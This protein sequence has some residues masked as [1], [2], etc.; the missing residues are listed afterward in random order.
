[1]L[2]PDLLAFADMLRLL[3]PVLPL[4]Q[5]VAEKVHA[6]THRYGPFQRPSTRVKDLVDLVLIE[7]TCTLRAGDLRA[8][9]R[10]TFGD[11]A[12]QPL[13]TS[14]PVPPAGW[15]VPYRDMASGLA[16]PSDLREGHRI[17]AVFL[18]P[19]LDGS[20]TDDS[21]WDA[22]SGRWTQEPVTGD[23]TPTA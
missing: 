13:P 12:S 23:G 19:I 15:E 22:R 20:I 2:G 11:R 5:H 18:D 6:Y 9:F 21:R 4:S 1:V 3:V 16:I 14:F 7:S 10:E 8:A 17:A